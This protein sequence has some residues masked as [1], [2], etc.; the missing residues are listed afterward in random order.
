MLVLHGQRRAALGGSR[1]RG[2]AP[3]PLSW[4]GWE[5]SHNFGAL[6]APAPLRG[7]RVSRDQSFQVALGDGVRPASVCFLLDLCPRNQHRSPAAAAASVRK[8]PLFR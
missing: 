2:R 7:S 3:P 8:S 6:V 5:L 1:G 4:Q